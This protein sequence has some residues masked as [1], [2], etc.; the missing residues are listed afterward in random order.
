LFALISALFLAGLNFYLY[1]KA[2]RLIERWRAGEAARRWR[3]GACAAFLVINAPYAALLVLWLFGG[4]MHQL[5]EPLLRIFF[6]PFFAWAA[7]LLTLMF[8]VP[9]AEL[10][11][12]TV[13]GLRRLFPRRRPPT[14]AALARRKFLATAAWA[15]PA[16]LFAVATKGVYA[17]SELEV[18]PLRKIPV[19]GLPRAFEGL[20]ITQLSD[21]HAGAFIREAELNRAVD[22]ANEL[23][24]DLVVITGDIMD[25]SLD[26]LPAA[27]AALSRLRAPLGIYGILGNHDYYADRRRDPGYPGCVRIMEGMQAAGVRMLRSQRATVRLGSDELLIIGLDWT[28]LVRGNPNMYVPE[29]TRAAIR[30]A[31]AGYQGQGPRLLLAHHPHSFYEAPEFGIALTLS[32]HTHGG[33]QVVVAEHNGHPIALGSAVFHYVSGLYC[34]GGHYLYVNRGLGFVLLPL[35]INCP[36]EISRFQLIKT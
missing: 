28:G 19:R 17:P 30:K 12:A 16:A 4:G 27:Q 11:S 20:T 35:R 29:I 6:Y 5:P 15:V 23:R 24:A 13:H 34:E 3:A 26:L 32:G 10:A 25:N 31:L 2:T 9:P 7:M 18:S 36:P 14:P 1:R 21:L 8:L 22:A 33:G